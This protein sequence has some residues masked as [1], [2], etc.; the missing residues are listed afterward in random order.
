MTHIL[1]TGGA[2]FIGSNTVQYALNLGFDVTVLDSF[3]NAVFSEEELRNL[4]AKILNID[5]REKEKIEALNTKYDSIIHLAAQVSVTKSFQSTEENHAINIVGSTNILQFAERLDID[6]FIFASSSAVYGD[7]TTM[8]LSES[9]LG[10][11]QSPYASSKHEIESQINQGFERGKEYLSLRFFN[12]Y[13][14]HQ[15]LDSNYGAV[16]PIFVNLLRN[17]EQPTIHG[18]GNQTRDFVHVNDVSKLLVDLATKEWPNPVQS[19][20]NVGTGIPTT[21]VDLASLI[22][23]VLDSKTK[24]QPNF[25]K[26]REGDIEQSVASIQATLRDLDWQPMTSLEDGIRQLIGVDSQ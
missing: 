26:P 13:G 2:G 6:R 19:V 21:V 1:I 25:G 22:H 17:G 3:E 12:V 14:P 10:T 20:Y 15:H 8:P 23:R 9:N 16:I 5:V 24:F 7:C 4:G 11:L 18:L